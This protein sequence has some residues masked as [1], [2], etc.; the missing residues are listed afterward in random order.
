MIESEEQVR[1]NDVRSSLPRWNSWVNC[2]QYMYGV[3]QQME[4]LMGCTK[5]R[6]GL[7]WLGLALLSDQIWSGG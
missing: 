5:A 7:V 2:S 1:D 4:E 3:P 6:L